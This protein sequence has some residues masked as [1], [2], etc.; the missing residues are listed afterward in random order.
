LSNAQNL[1]RPEGDVADASVAFAPL[2]RELLDAWPLSDVVGVTEVVVGATNR[3]YRI[4][5]L[6][7]VAFLKLYRRK[8]RVRAVREHALIRYVANA[9]LPAPSPIATSSGDTVVERG[10]E[11]AALYEPARGTQLA[12]SRLTLEQA[13]SAGQTL[14]ELHARLAALPD[15]GYA[16]RKLAWD[17]P[18]WVERLDVV[19]RAIVAR[20]ERN[21]T[22][23]WA[24]ERLQAQRAWLRQPP[25]S[26]SHDPSFA[27]QVIH[28]DYQDANLFFTDQQVTAIIDW[29]ES[30]LL[31]RAYEVVR[32]C[33]FMF[34][35][36]PTST[37]AFL[38]GYRE[39]TTLGQAELADG[40]ASWGCNADHHVWPLEEVYL[41]GNDRAR[42]FIPHTAFRPF[43]EQ[44]RDALR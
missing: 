37:Q 26:H 24:I 19:E 14:G 2:I 27:S 10:G 44:W 36:T 16:R 5:C 29:D 30:T 31:P 41:H 34:R 23:V 1:G 39:A 40:A 32:A 38:A 17:G 12:S 9:G 7:R 13:R 42:R 4:E 35:C 20:R 8:D 18:Q 22:D 6:D 28:G 21:A 33:S 25:C 3:V 43:A 15:M 11:F